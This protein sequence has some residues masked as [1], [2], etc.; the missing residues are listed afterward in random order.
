MATPSGRPP[1]ITPEPKP[2]SPHII[3]S[4]DE[5]ISSQTSILPSLNS[6]NQP[7]PLI[8][9]KSSEPSDAILHKKSVEPLS[10]RALNLVHKDANHLPPI[11]PLLTPALQ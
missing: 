2:Q 1:T 7:Q 5:S 9:I 10:I 8:E 3:P 6:D 4:Y 11:P